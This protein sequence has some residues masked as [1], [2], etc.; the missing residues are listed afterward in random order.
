VERTGCLDLWIVLPLANEYEQVNTKR[1]ESREVQANRGF[2]FLLSTKRELRR[3][4]V[5]VPYGGL[6]RRRY[7][8]GE[9]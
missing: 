7:S 2:C 5:M 3:G 8:R 9:R 1:I 6:S 4:F